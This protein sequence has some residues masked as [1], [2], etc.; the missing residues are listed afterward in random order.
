[1]VTTALEPTS[2]GPPVSPTSVQSAF[3]LTPFF[4][5]SAA[6]S[7]AVLPA[8][9]LSTTSSWVTGDVSL[10]VNE[11]WNEPLVSFVMPVIR[12]AMGTGM[13]ILTMLLVLGIPLTNTVASA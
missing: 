5:A 12:G 4:L 13:L 6:T 7:L 3:A 8:G 2:T 9:S 1:M 11:N 10:L